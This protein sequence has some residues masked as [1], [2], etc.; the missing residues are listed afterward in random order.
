MTSCWIPYSQAIIL[1]PTGPA[2]A[3]GPTGPPSGIVGPTGLPGKDGATGPQGL[4]GPTGPTGPAGADGP[5]GPAGADGATGPAGAA[6]A[7]GVAGAD[8][9]T[10]PTGAQGPTGPGGSGGGNLVKLVYDSP[11]DT[12]I[13][14]PWPI[15]SNNTPADIIWVTMSAGGGGSGGC[16]V[17]APGIV[18]A[19]GGG[20]GFIRRLPIYYS[21]IYN[22]L[23]AQIGRGGQGG[24]GTGPN[25]ANNPSN[26]GFGGDT[27][28][29]LTPQN[30]IRALGGGG[31][32]AAFNYADLGGYT[33]SGGYGGGVQIDE[34][35]QPFGI[36]NLLIPKRTL[37]SIARGERW[38][39]DPNTGAITQITPPETSFLNGYYESGSG[40]R[41][42]Y[43]VGLGDQITLSPGAPSLTSVRTVSNTVSSSIICAGGSS[44]LPNYGYGA[45]SIELS[46]F[47]ISQGYAGLNGGDGVIII[48]YMN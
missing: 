44:G 14:I 3:Q 17:N 26:G 47:G 9:A 29:R 46:I 35:I 38:Q 31:G 34:I 42:G 18:G 30:T 25:P 32:G 16:N 12:K 11:L 4:P 5:A 7:A 27:F 36:I 43:S 45:D 37:V 39:I 23:D 48:E 20:G 8:G 24:I 1:G 21:T 22:F 40:G 2:G 15:T 28:L 19:P 33:P 10:G 6:G 41:T 13:T